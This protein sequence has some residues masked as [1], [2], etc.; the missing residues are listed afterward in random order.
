MDKFEGTKSDL[1]I[2]FIVVII[3]LFISLLEVYYNINP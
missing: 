1:L 3:S 2:Y